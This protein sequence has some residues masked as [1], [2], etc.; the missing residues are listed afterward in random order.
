MGNLAKDASKTLTI[1]ATVAAKG[2]GDKEQ[3]VTAHIFR[4]GDLGY[5]GIQDA[6]QKV[7]QTYE[8]PSWT[9]IRRTTWPWAW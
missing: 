5:H 4:H 9:R 1:T 6:T 8:V 2:L 3:T 7:A